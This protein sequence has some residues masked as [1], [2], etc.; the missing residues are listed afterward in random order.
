MLKPQGFLFLSAPWFSP[1]RK[2]KAWD[3]GYAKV[4]PSNEPESFY[5][6]ALGREEVCAQLVRHGFQLQSW[7]DCVSEISMKADMSAFQRQ[8]EWLLGS[9]GPIVK[10]VFRRVIVRSLDWYCG[11]SFLAIARRVT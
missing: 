6:F 2:A 11:H 9:R 7:R 10:R 1:Y 3:G 5:Q 8:I 4:D